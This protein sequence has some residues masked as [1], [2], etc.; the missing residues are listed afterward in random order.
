MLKCEHVARDV[1]W[2]R[3]VRKFEVEFMN[4]LSKEFVQFNLY[5]VLAVVWESE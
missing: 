1:P 4:E 5:L 3:L 2:L